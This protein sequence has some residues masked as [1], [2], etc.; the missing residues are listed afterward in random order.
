[1]SVTAFEDFAPGETRTYGDYLF[2][3]EEI[4]AFAEIYDA[5]PF[6]IDAE[7]AKHT[8]LGGLAA[9]GWHTCSALMRMFVD[10]WLRDTTCLAGV[11]VEDNRWL[12][13]VRPGDRLTAATTTLEKSE[14]RSRPDA[15]IV[16]FATS[17]RNQAGQEVMAQTCSILFARRE[18][19]EASPPAAWPPRPE[20]AP[21][22]ARIEDPLGALPDDYERARV[23]AFADLGATEFTADFI[24]GYAEK[25]D[26]M[27]FHVDEAAGRAHMLGA[28]SAAG[29]QT[30]SCWM[31]HFIELRRKAAAGGEVPSRASPGVSAM[32]W[33]KPVL[34]GDR[35]AFFT[36]VVA[37]RPTSK[38]GL[39]LVQSRNWGVNQRGETAIEFMASVFSPI[40]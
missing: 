14:P 15:G 2:T 29:W 27:P 31:K 19:L 22:P 10:G 7:A 28:M 16:K 5:Q 37:K 23:G 20:P 17:L 18:P 1:M 24:R 8:I 40:A 11:G 34:L 30:A 12:A 9:S 39:G 4:V 32:V 3:E 36:E 33:R 25:F 21:A 13:P 38:P 6:H 35:I 26:P